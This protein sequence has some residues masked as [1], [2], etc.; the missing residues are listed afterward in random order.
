ML[1]QEANLQDIAAEEE[2][3]EV[4][5]TPSRSSGK[6]DP[7][8]NERNISII[9]N[10][11]E[12][13]VQEENSVVAG[14]VRNVL[15]R[16]LKLFSG[17]HSN[18]LFSKKIITKIISKSQV[19]DV[20]EHYSALKS[21]ARQFCNKSSTR[22]PEHR[23]SR[24]LF[25]TA[26]VATVYIV[27]SVVLGGALFAMY[28]Q[29]LHKFQQICSDS[30]NPLVSFNNF[31]LTICCPYFVNVLCPSLLSSASGML[32]GATHGGMYYTMDVFVDR[33]LFQ[34]QFAGTTAKPKPSPRLASA[35]LS[36]GLVYTTLF[37]VYD[38]TKHNSLFALQF[39][40]RRAAEDCKISHD[41]EGAI[42]VMVGA[43]FA[44]LAS[45][46]V[47][48]VTH[49]ME[50]KSLK[51]IVRGEVS[52][53]PQRCNVKQPFH[54]SYFRGTIPA[55]CSTIVGFLAYEYAKLYIGDFVSDDG[56]QQC[57]K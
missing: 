41:V 51:S 16:T 57:R 43:T 31:N 36:H 12:G 56:Q 25:K 6:A 22:T 3:K 55:I 44:G 45:E 20:S 18:R 46:M 29:S 39:Y 1:H 2:V 52:F 30:R 26:G 23:P 7:C 27:K 53:F 35:M 47:N 24:S 28:E 9:S 5:S 10:G 8:A 50:S 40:N 42:S 4:M 54:W 15:N 33:P 34:L 38:F 48:S 14:S 32:A 13:S 37:G 21:E 49:H 11:T 19:H 17:E